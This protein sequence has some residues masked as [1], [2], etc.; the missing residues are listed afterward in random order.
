MIRV[1]DS[2]SGEIQFLDATLGVPSSWAWDF[3]S[4]GIIDDTTRSAT[5]YFN[6]SGSYNT[7]L[8]VTNSFGTNSKT[9]QNAFIISLMDGP[10]IETIYSCKGDS[11]VILSSDE[12]NLNWYVN[13]NDLEKLNEGPSLLTDNIYN[14]TS[15]FA[16][17]SFDTS[18]YRTGLTYFPSNGLNSSN[19]S[20]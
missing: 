3:E 15:F 10:L 19:Y 7:T 1:E 11:V 6:Q 9:I 16:S 20:I 4:D 12:T 2:C 17:L 18:C 13:E 8:T 14:D 5:S